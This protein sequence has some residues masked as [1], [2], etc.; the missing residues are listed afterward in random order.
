MFA[1]LADPTRLRIFLLVREM[2]LSM[3]ELAE[4]LGQSQPRVSRH[5]RILAEAGLVRRSKEGAWVFVDVDESAP[6]ATVNALVAEVANGRDLI[7]DEHARLAEVRRERQRTLDAWF[8]EKAGEWDLVTKLGGHEPDVEAALRTAARQPE[9]GRL[10]DIGTGT[11]LVLGLLASEARWAVGID[12]SPEMLRLARAKLSEGGRQLAD[13]QHADMRALPFGNGSFDT[14]TLVQV[15]H[16][17]D[18][19]ASV[20]TEAARVLADG[21]KL[22]IA[23]FAPHNHEELRERFH[24]A[25]LGFE[26]ATVLGWMTAAGLTARVVSRH[27]G[28]NLQV[29]VTEGRK[30]H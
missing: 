23:E 27:P 24:H 20:V 25:R 1:A 22:L 5:V 9:V 28:N 6:L 3:G 13:L 15:L 21:G 7:A 14:V 30:S 19:P 4:I 26:E 29:H 10:L 2:Q 18:D 12:R 17:S 11:G 16:F 8:A